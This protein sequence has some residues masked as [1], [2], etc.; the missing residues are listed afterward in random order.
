MT[1]TKK[2]W[3]VK[4]RWA[5]LGG[6]PVGLVALPA[7]ALAA[8]FALAGI[9]GSGT[10]GEFTAKWATGFAPTMDTSALTVQPAGT[11]AVNSGRLDLPA[12]T[13]YPNETFTVE[14]PIVSGAASQAGYVAGVA[15]PGLPK[16]ATAE[17]VSGCGVKVTNSMQYVKV[18]VTAPAALVAGGQW[19]LAADSGVKVTPLAS[20]TSSAPAGVTCPVFTAP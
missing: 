14:A 16:G 8:Y 20:S 18:K 10:N 1:D 19:S 2:T 7:A 11:A 4:K 13:I 17:L 9:S 6:V 3:S 12:L 15:M 5:I